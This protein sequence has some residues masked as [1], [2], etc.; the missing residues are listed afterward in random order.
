MCVDQICFKL[1]FRGIP[2]ILETMSNSTHLPTIAMTSDL[3]VTE[4]TTESP[5]HVIDV[6][7]PPILIAVGVTCNVLIILVM[8]T[9]QFCRQSTSVF[10]TT[11]AI[12]DALGLVVSMTT[13]WLHVS[14]DRIYYRHDVSNI[15]KFLDFYGWGNCDFGIL[16]TSTMTV[17]RA[18]AMT[19]PLK[20]KTKSVKRARIT[21]LV[22][23]LIVVAKE[24]HFLI[25][26]K[27]VPESR[28]ERLC[29][30]FPATDSYKFFWKDVWPWFHLSYLSV[31]FITIISSNIVLV[32]QIFKSIKFEKTINRVTEN[33]N[34]KGKEA[35]KINHT[36]RTRNHLHAIAPMLIGESAV[37]LVLTFPFSVHLAISEYNPEFYRQLDTSL[38]FSVT[39]YMLYTN[40][41]VTFFVYLVTGSKFRESLC[42]VF[43]RC[44]KGKDGIRRNRF[45]TLSQWY[46]RRN[47][48]I[49]SGGRR[50][51]SP[52]NGRAWATDST[53]CE[54]MT[55]ESQTEP[56]YIIS[57][58][59]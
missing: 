40:K 27:M 16:I 26:S 51:S 39:F 35:C 18:L 28:K 58:H 3:S 41:C 59:M 31:C 2:N 1:Y 42:Q 47:S 14:F 29:D 20:V 54:T 57:T 32:F 15:C 46:L 23:T 36:S 17:D 19:F 45:D 12:N 48:N 13:H 7:Y 38:V 44:W 43:W 34:S 11:G 33:N 9:K 4:S 55:S 5:P 56:N 25:G 21:V 10:M 37:M 52:Q 8:R 53:S 30:V 24:F 22:L 49:S 6:V 50:K